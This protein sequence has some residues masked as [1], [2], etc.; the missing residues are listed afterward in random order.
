MS[1]GTHCPSTRPHRSGRL[2]LLT[3]ALLACGACSLPAWADQP[4]A[5]ASTT[6]MGDYRFSIH[7][8]PLVSAINTFS[9]VTGWQVGFNAQ[10]A[11]GVASPGVQGS[12]TT[13]AALDRMQRGTGLA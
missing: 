2:S 8:Q 13:E 4:A 6:R 5:S 1:T 10:L 9:Q 12:L 7:Q 3:L 11:D